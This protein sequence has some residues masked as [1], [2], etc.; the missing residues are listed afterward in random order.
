MVTKVDPSVVDDQV[1]G[2]RNIII[3][4]DMRIA[5]RSTSSTG[6]GDYVLDRF[7][8]D[9]NGGTVTYAQSALSSSDTPYT[10][11]F[12]SALKLTNTS[13]TIVSS[14]GIPIGIL[15]HCMN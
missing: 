4:G 5:E 15:Q 6:S 9:Y 12:R 7:Y 13:T 2:R 3:N 14:K 8:N 11:G 10:H 1:F